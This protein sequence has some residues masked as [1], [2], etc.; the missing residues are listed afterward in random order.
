MSLVDYPFEDED[1]EENEGMEDEKQNV[2]NE[3]TQQHF[4]SADRGAA[5]SSSSSFLAGIQAPLSGADVPLTSKNAADVSLR[6]PDASELLSSFS[7][8]ATMYPFRAPVTVAAAAS[9]KR[10]DLNGSADARHKKIP[11]SN[12]TTSRTPVDTAGGFLVPPQLRGR[13]NIATEDLD[14]LFT[15]RQSS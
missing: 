10:P 3:G 7:S 4:H 14:R 9:R 13:S 1:E 15:K 2:L 5:S 6:L 8:G 12:L 11:K